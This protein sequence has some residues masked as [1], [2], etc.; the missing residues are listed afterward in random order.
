MIA[1]NTTNVRYV[2]SELLLCTIHKVPGKDGVVAETLKIRG[3]SLLRKL[4]EMVRDVWKS[5]NIPDERNAV[6][7]CPY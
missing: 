2:I 5:E 4:T 3:I 6:V 1:I 7:I